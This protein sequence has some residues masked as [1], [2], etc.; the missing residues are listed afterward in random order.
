M[1]KHTCVKKTMFLFSLLSLLI[2]GA[3]ACGK[4][5]TS[6]SSTTKKQAISKVSLNN[7]A[8]KIDWDQLPTT[9]ITLTNQSLKITKAGTYVLSGKTDAGVIVQTK[10]NVRLTLKNATI[11]NN[12]GAAIYSKKAKNTVIQLATGTENL[13]EDA[14]T[15]SDKTIDGAIYSE[16]NLFF[17][18][19]G[20]LTV[21]AN[22]ADGIVSKSDLTFDNGTFTIKSA[23][24]GIRGKNSVSVTGG[25]LTVDAAGDGMK[26][27]NKRAAEKGFVY[28]NGGDIVITT[29]DD[30]IHAEETLLINK[31]TIK[32]AS[33]V[34]GLEAAN[35][36]INNGNITVN[37]SDDGINAVD[38]DFTAAVMTFNGGTIDVTVGAGDTDAID[39][40]GD[41][42]V[43][44]G[45]IKITSTVSAFDYDEKAVYKSGT[46]IING[47]QVDTIPENQMGGAGGN[48]P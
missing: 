40:N 23:D 21:T 24:D 9:A 34:E 48:R 33:S 39:S 38:S 15:R 3:A 27:T 17:T 20:K 14:S 1:K 16:N 43:N 28:I 41:I 7:A 44:G 8:K 6:S 47:E 19:M 18:G 45:T 37:A 13:V 22:F 35:L 31:G 36:T 4:Q 12:A 32:I 30:G 2:F 10:G 11:K 42:Y 46:I 29:G 5:D 25:A 26:A